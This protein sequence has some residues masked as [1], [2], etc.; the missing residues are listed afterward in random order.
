MVG[1]LVT[2]QEAPSLDKAIINAR[3]T[4][5]LIG[6]LTM[7]LL[8]LALLSVVMRADSII[9]IRTGAWPDKAHDVEE[10]ETKALETAARA[11]R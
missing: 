3:I 11:K 10:M 7:G 2:I 6:A 4:G 8:F 9:T 1:V 5:L